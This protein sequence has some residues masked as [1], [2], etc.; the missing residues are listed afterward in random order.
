MQQVTNKKQQLASSERRLTICEQSKIFNY[1]RV[2]T[3]E[4]KKLC[5]KYQIANTGERERE[6]E[7]DMRSVRHEVRVGI[8]AMNGESC[9]SSLKS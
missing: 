1:Q 9:D 6:R 3:R 8:L 5:N 4:N 7:S 2:L